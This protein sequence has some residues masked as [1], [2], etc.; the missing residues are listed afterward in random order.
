M[1]ME[2]LRAIGTT[3]KP[4]PQASELAVPLMEEF[5]E[6]GY[7]EKIEYNLPFQRSK[8]KDIDKSGPVEDIM[9]TCIHNLI[10]CIGGDPDRPG[11][12]ETPKR[13]RKMYQ[14]IFKGMKYTN[15][16]IAEID[17]EREDLKA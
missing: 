12:Q 13:V 3:G 17:P 7:M 5:V 6:R 14:E 15:E 11:L 8:L 1:E 9:E 16:D 10:T 2:S 4:H